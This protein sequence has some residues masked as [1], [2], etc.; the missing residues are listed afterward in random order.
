VKLAVITSRWNST[1]FQGK[2]LAKIKGKPMLQHIVDRARES[3]VDDVA[4]A[5]TKSSPE[6]IKYCEKN[7][8]Y[9]YAHYNEWDILS[10][11]LMTARKYRADLIVYLWG[12]APLIDPDVISYCVEYF[13][14]K[15]P[16]YYAHYMPSGVVGVVDIGRLFILSANAVKPV[17]REYIHEY[18][19]KMGEVKH[20]SGK[21]LTVDEPKDIEELEDV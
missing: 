18:M 3:E 6:I 4:V 20:Y 13:E 7:H 15:R 1:R 17:D 8:I 10:R 14:R 21:I 19:C 9:W 11:L 16:K 5:T 12:D 2:A